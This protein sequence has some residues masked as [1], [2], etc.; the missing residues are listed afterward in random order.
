M[1]TFI[2]QM[3]VRDYL[4]SIKSIDDSVG[5]V[6]EYLEMSFQLENTLVI[7]TSDVG[8]FLGD[9]GMY[10]SRFMYEKSIKVPLVMRSPWYINPGHIESRMALNLDIGPSVLDI[11]Q[12]DYP[13]DIQGVSLLPLMENCSDFK[14]NYD[15]K[16][17]TTVITDWKCESK[18]DK[19]EKKDDK[20]D[21]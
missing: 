17:N 16:T 2:Y 3:Y 21:K 6:I 19:K 5:R 11:A 1:G 14:E 12:A 13:R 8:E 18:D 10:G 7:Y 15:A 20:K 9:R 4:Q